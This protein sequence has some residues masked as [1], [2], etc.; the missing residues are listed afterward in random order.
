MSESQ[1]E[2]NSSS[3]IDEVICNS[4]GQW[5]YIL[6]W[7]K[8]LTFKKVTDSKLAGLIVR[9]CFDIIDLINSLQVGSF[10]ST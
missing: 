6:G 4:C 5:I 7:K 8:Y 3:N 10:R 9:N 1:D 2:R